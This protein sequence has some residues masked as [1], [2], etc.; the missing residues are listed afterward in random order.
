MLRILFPIRNRIDQ[1]FAFGGIP[2]LTISFEIEFP[3]QRPNSFPTMVGDTL[4]LSTR[5]RR[6]CTSVVLSISNIIKSSSLTNTLLKGNETPFSFRVFEYFQESLSLCLPE[7]LVIRRRSHFRHDFDFFLIVDNQNILPVRLGRVTDGHVTHVQ[8]EGEFTVSVCYEQSEPRLGWTIGH[9][10]GR[11][12]FV[13]AEGEVQQLTVE[14][15]QLIVDHV[16][17]AC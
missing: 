16:A 7:F 15:V 6:Y 9:Q 8:L 2:A 1:V 3:L 5:S 11:I 13:C 17:G 12:V 14:C 10:N 4:T